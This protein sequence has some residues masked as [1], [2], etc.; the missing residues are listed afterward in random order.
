MI[1]EIERL[2]FRYESQLA[3]DDF[4]LAIPEGSRIALV[5]ANGF[6]QIDAAACP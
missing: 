2:A 4:S 3:L 1:Y 6:W 5:G